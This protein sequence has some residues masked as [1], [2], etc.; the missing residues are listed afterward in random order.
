VSDKNMPT[1]AKNKMWRLGSDLEREIRFG[2]IL[3]GEFK[4]INIEEKIND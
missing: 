3:V 2:R 4:L 1:H